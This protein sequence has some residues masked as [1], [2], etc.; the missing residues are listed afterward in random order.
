MI[1]KIGDNMI[2]K[3]AVSPVIATVLLIVMV[4]IIGLIIFLW[5]RSFIPE[6]K[7]KFGRN[8]ELVCADVAF[9]SGY[10]S[11]TG[12]LT[13]SNTG[14]V[15]IYSINLKITKNRGHTTTS[16]TELDGNWPSLGLRQ[17]ILYNSIDFSTNPDFDSPDKILIIPILAGTSEGEDPT[18]AC[19]EEYGQELNLL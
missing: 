1:I 17:G 16:I 12:I 9:Q 19:N 8:I 2:N 13:I 15:P 4:I 7:E 6:Q 11:S 14:T 3:K 5:F 10:D 18:Y